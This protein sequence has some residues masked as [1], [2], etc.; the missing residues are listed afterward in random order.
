M[1]RRRIVA[2]AVSCLLAVAALPAQTPNTCS[3]LQTANAHLNTND[4]VIGTTIYDGDR[5]ETNSKGMLS[6]RSGQIQ[7][8]LSE[9]STLWMNHENSVV[10]PVLQ[11]GTVTFRAE[12]G[13]GIEVKADDVRV[14]PHNPVLTAGEVTLDD[15]YV[16]V[17][18]RT[19]QLEVTAAKETRIL[20]EG[21]AYR[22]A[23]LGACGPAHGSAPRAPGGGRF[24]VAPAAAVGGITVWVVLEALESPDRP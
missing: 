11:R 12:T 9:N 17:T 4:A 22:I 2:I 16:Y 13:F 8:I 20:D 5:L 18:A 3:I 21:K 19:Q 6:V 10:T 15:C 14:R 1:I 23:R 7:L 24:W